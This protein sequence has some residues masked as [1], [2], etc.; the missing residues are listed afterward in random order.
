MFIIIIRDRQGHKTEIGLFSEQH[1][2]A[3]AEKWLQADPFSRAEIVR[4][5]HE[6]R[7][8]ERMWGPQ[9]RG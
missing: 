2:K 4:P 5:G 6:K 1:A 3:L 7:R 9:V 8:L